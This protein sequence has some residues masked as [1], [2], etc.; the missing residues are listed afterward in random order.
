[1]PIFITITQWLD[2]RYDSLQEKGKSTTLSSSSKAVVGLIPVLKFV[3]QV[4]TQ[5]DLACL[6]VLE[7]GILDTLLRIYVIF[8]ALSSKLP[9]DFGRKS[10]LMDAC[11]LTVV[12]LCR[13]LEKPQMVYNH[14]VCILWTDRD[15]KRPDNPLQNRCGAWRRVPRSC[16]LR[17]L[18]VIYT[19]SLWKSNSDIIGGLEACMDIIEFTK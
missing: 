5:S 10:T 13:L 11:Q 2:N 1:M 8:P 16:A 4:A 12:V 14:P 17:R 19:G 15:S 6:T 7:A 9:E 3:T 18:V